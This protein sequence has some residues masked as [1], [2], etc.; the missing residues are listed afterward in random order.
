MRRREGRTSPQRRMALFKGYRGLFRDWSWQWFAT[1]TFA[2]EYRRIKFERADSMVKSWL[3]RICTLEGIQ[4]GAFYSLC[5]K[6]GRVH[7]HLVMMGYGRTRGRRSLLDVDPQVWERAWPYL[8]RIEVIN[9]QAATTKYLAAQFL[10]NEKTE[11][12]FYNANLLRRERII[13]LDS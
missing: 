5:R 4:V 8:A 6:R 1:L 7:V 11:I 3:R 10:L 13:E 9:S 2:G 12:D